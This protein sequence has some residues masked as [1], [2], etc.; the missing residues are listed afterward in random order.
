MSDYTQITSF[1]PKDS[2][3]TGD[4]NKKIRG[5]QLDPE[6]AAIATA[7]QSKFDSSDLASDAQAAALTSDSVLMTPDKVAHALQN[8]TLTLG[9][10]I[11]LARFPNVS[12]N[13]TSS[14]TELNILDGVTATAT[15][16][17]AL[18]GFTGDAADLNNVVSRLGGIKVAFCVVASDGTLSTSPPSHGITSTSRGSTGTYTIN[19]TAAGFSQPP[20]II[21]DA[22]TGSVSTTINGGAGTSTSATVTTNNDLSSGALVDRAFHFFAIGI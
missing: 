9:T 2:L 17:N 12:G 5:S 1:A 3:T 6:F 7:I 20:V 16:L 14:H 4:S 8:A 19:Y 13:V 11:S 21:T 10:G 18:D 15:E 22:V